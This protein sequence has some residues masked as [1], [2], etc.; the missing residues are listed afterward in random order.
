VNHL[1]ILGA[2]GDL[3]ARL[4]LPALY[5]LEARRDLE[6]LHII[7]YGLEA[8]SKKEFVAHVRKA[9]DGNDGMEEEVW[10]RLAGR[11][12][13]RSGDLTPK[14]LRALPS[15]ESAG[16]TVYY[17]A[18][19][20]GLFP[21]AATGIAEA[22]L[23]GG[24]EHRLVVEK[25]FG[26]D[27]RSAR[28]L[29]AELHRHWDETSIFRIDHFL[30]KE[31]VQ[32][33]M[34]MRFAN[35]SLEPLLCAAHVDHVQI[36]VAETL[37]LEGR[38]RYYDGIGAL[39]DM[40]QNHLMQLFCLSAMEAPSIWDP[41]VLRDHKVEILRAVRRPTAPVDT[42]A[43]RGQY[44]GG[45]LQEERVPAYR[46]EPHIDPRSRTETFAA[47]RLQ[48]DNWRWEGV[49]FYLRSGKRLGASCSEIAYRFR[50]PPTQLFE[51][52]PLASA[53]PNWLVFRLGHPEGVDLFL[54][55]KRP[56]LELEA[57]LT[58]LHADYGDDRTEATAY[59][60]LLLD[61]LEGDHTPFLRVDEV[62]EAWRLLDPILGAWKTGDPEIY[63]AG[64]SGPSGQDRILL[65]GHA[66]R[67]IRSPDTR[68][69]G[70][71]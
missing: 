58:R 65:P 62:E 44:G 29:N 57:D 70:T 59:E 25:P 18:L 26:T 7:G 60:Q 33:L 71:T 12:D 63:G 69:P 39:R 35:R 46:D 56:G 6:D 48:V 21:E 31:T 53:S 32:N 38:Y 24:G 55:A 13:Y 45:T 37:G 61:V 20:P 11:L 41:T 16:A 8:W 28:E 43:S 2:S 42:W 1:I 40:I 51:E 54:Q 17:L 66:W 15:D 27:L 19:P 47:V 67:P 49:P 4:L 10:E 5:R 23:S 68:S 34:V 22:G 50:Q 52:T 9:L 30:G 36:T 64:T 14:A 3:A